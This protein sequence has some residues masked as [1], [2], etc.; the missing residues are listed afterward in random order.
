MI[1]EILNHTYQYEAEKLLR[2]FF[3]NEKIHVVFEKTEN[4]EG[5]VLTTEI[6]DT[7]ALAVFHDGKTAQKSEALLSGS[8]DKEL[9]LA[10]QMYKVLTA[11]TGYTPKWGLLTGIRP[12]K[13]LIALQEEMGKE[14]AAR[15]FTERFFVSP[16]KTALAES[17][18]ARENAIIAT[19]K[20]NSC[21]L[22]V[23]IPF[24]PTRCSYCSF[25]SHA[26]SSPSVKKLIPDYV[27]LLSQEIAETGKMAK[28]LGLNLESVYFGGGTPTTLNAEELGALLSA[29]DKAFD[30]TTVREYTVEA[31]RPDTITQEKLDT[32]YQGGVTRISINPQTFND[33]V[34]ENIGRKHTAAMTEEA[35]HMARDAGFRNINMDLIAGLPGDTTDSFAA[36]VDKAI[37]FTPENITVHTLSLKRSSNMGTSGTHFDR[38]QGRDADEM[39]HYAY[40]A[41][42]KQAYFP[43]Y[44]YRQARTLGNLENTG[45][46]KDGFECLY[47]IFM[48]E[49]CH[50]VFAVGAGA[51]TKLKAPHGKE[52]E[53][54]FNYKYPYEYIS[55]FSEL[56]KRKAAIME[57]YKKYGI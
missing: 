1:L 40:K 2:V 50:T 55:G 25:V 38:L 56:Q 12:S 17:V 41:L 48:M 28:E 54:I 16:E 30:L 39:L 5:A 22:Y 34:L 51:V 26:I 35:F 33:R 31:G 29:V 24:C 42:T 21:S 3:P 37:S 46:T 8:D 9:L 13:L 49:E 23:S 27:A 20:P 32:L 43:Y 15:Y 19:S 44:M 4:P 52:I 53:R 6:T 47:N 36:S 11:V 14:N 18:A 7:H 57:F 45:Y 10:T